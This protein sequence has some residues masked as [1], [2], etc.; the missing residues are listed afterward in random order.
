MDKIKNYIAQRGYTCPRGLVENYYLSLMARPFVILTGM[1]GTDMTKL[2]AL[3]AEAVGATAENGRY[4]CLEVEYDWMDS[5]DLFGHLDLWGKFVPGKILDFLKQAHQDPQHPYFLCFDRLILSRAEYFLREI[6]Q[7]AECLGAG[8]EAPE[9]VPQIYYGRDEQAKQTYGAIPALNN[10]YIVCTLALDETGLPLNQKFMDR[11][12][13]LQIGEEDVVC[14][15]EDTHPVAE[16]YTNDFFHTPLRRLEQCGQYGDKVQG[17][18]ATIEQLNKILMQINAYVGYQ[19]RNDMIL[20]L[21]NA[22]RTGVL[23]EEE[24]LDYLITR[25]VL[26]RAQGNA[27]TVVPVLEQLEEYCRGKYP[28]AQ[29]KIAQ[30]AEKCRL[31]ERTFYWL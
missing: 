30:M 26:V 7:V 18:I 27:K 12:Y 9:L 16:C 11:V 4:L 28:M 25:K 17:F 21:L 24:A 1:S 22:L 5:S 19:V 3:F 8:E 10:L 23:S 14:D 29:K 6:L 13:T 15:G 31:E 2:P 20:Y